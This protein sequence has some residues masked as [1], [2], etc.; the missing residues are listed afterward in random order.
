MTSRTLKVHE[1]IECVDVHA[2]IPLKK[3]LFNLDPRKDYFSGSFFNPYS[4]R[5]SLPSIEQGGLKLLWATHYVPELQLFENNWIFDLMTS[6]FV[7]REKL[8]NGTPFDRLE[9]MMTQFKNEIDDLEGAKLVGN[10]DDLNAVLDS[11]TIGF[12]HAIEGAHVLDGDLDNLKRLS[13]AGVVS[14]TLAHFYHNGIV[15]QVDAIPKQ[16]PI[17]KV[18]SFN[19]HEHDREILTEFG[20]DVIDNLADLDIIPDLTHC[21]PAA[22]HEIY[23]RYPSEEPLIFTH[24]GLD[25]FKS[26]PMNPTDDEIQEIADRG[27]AI[28]IILYNYWLSDD[29]PDH[30]LP[31]VWETVNHIYEV[32]G[33]WDHVMIGSDFDGF[34]EPPLDVIDHSQFGKLTEKFLNKGLS[35]DAIEKIMGANAIRLM[36][37]AWS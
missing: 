30:S 14:L 2:H 21:V 16:H 23:N 28:G 37:D 34:T 3:W 15:R 32:T 7:G 24:V 17:R 31:T 26:D 8:R 13:E 12:V 25:K 36:K 6:I 20:Q 10:L 18:S 19:F 11:N 33:S 35:T 29:D 22:R 9:E 27:G 1:D 5:T 4:Y